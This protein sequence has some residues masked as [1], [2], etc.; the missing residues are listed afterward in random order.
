MSTD[1]YINRRQRLKDLGYPSTATWAADLY[2]DFGIN[3]TA[4][5]KYNNKLVDDNFWDCSGA[6]KL[7]SIDDIVNKVGSMSSSCLQAALLP[8]LGKMLGDSYDKFNKIY[9]DFTGKYHDFE[10]YAHMAMES[11]I[12]ITMW[13]GAVATEIGMGFGP[14]WKCKLTR[15]S[16]FHP[17]LHL[18]STGYQNT[19]S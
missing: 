5:R 11:V 6:D 3:G 2:L 12:D 8:A 13:Q 1:T 7:I 9:G 15:F 14:A 17:S 4:N 19:N 10:D 16:E 18:S